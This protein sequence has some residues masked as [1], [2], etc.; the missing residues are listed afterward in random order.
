MLQIEE[1]IR[2]TAWYDY[3]I[4]NYKDV[5]RLLALVMYA[6]LTGKQHAMAVNQVNFK[7][8]SKNGISISKQADLV[9]SIDPYILQLTVSG[10]QIETYYRR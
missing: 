2:L 4:R 1:N 7:S 5:Y 9:F 10:M 6:I 8:T 3:V